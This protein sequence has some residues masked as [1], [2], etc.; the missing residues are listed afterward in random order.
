MRWRRGHSYF[1]TFTVR[2]YAHHTR[3]TLPLR[4]LL[5]RTSTCTPAPAPK[6]Y[7]AYLLP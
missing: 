5:P 3:D 2:M 7:A 4:I 6:R 1:S